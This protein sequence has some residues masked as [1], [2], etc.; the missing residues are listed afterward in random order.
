MKELITNPYLQLM[1]IS[2]LPVVEL[3][4]GIPY[5]VLALDLPFWTVYWLCVLGNL[6]PVPFL[7]K[8]SKAVVSW[9]AEKRV[10]GDLFGKIIRRADRQS[11]T[12]GKWELFGLFVFVLLPGPGTGAWTGS[13]IAA[14]LRMRL[15]PA[16]L[17]IAL[18]I[19]GSGIVMGMLSFGLLGAFGI[20][21]S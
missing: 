19:M 1:V 8:F 7:I 9:L 10:L 17:V 15:L 5:G 20:F 14:I 21:A 18:A 3:R 4:G 11:K 12:L 16:T 2:A 6:L 13:L